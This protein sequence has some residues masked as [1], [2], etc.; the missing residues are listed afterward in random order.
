MSEARRYAILIGNSEFPN[1]P[2]LPA[3]RCPQHDVAG[4]G[5]VLASADFG[6]FTDVLPL[7]NEPHYK[8]KPA[9]NRVFRQ[10]ARQDQIL[11]YYSGHGKQDAVGHLH[12]ATVDTEAEALETTSVEVGLLPRLIDNH[13]CKQVAL[14]LDCC[15]SGLVGKDF[16]K[17]GVDDQLQ[18]M[19]E[20]RGIYILTASTATQTAREKEGDRYSVLTKHILQGI[21][22]G[23]ADYDDDGLVS[24]DDLYE[25]VRAAVP[26]DSPQHPMKWVLGIQ[27]KLAI[28]RAAKIYQAEQLREFKAKVVSVEEFLPDEVFDH[29]LQIIRA[30]QAK[31]DK[32]FLLLLEAL[33]HRSMRVGE[34][35]SRWL[36]LTAAP[37]VQPP[38]QS[39]APPVVPRQN[40][41]QPQAPAS[42][43]PAKLQQPVSFT[44][45]LNDV[46]L[47]MVYLPGDTFK[48]GS[49]KGK[50]YDSERPQH[51]VTVPGFFIGK[52]QITQVQW[53]AVMGNNPAHFKGDNLPV[54][55]VSWEDAQEF[56]RRLSQLTGEAYRLPSE[57][58][59]EYACRAGTTG[60]YA[61]E[62]DKLAW[63]DKNSGQKTHPVGEKEPNAFGLYDMHGNVWECC[64]D[65]WHGNYQGAPSDGSAWVKDSK[66]QPRVVRGGSWRFINGYCRSASRY[67]Y[68][69]GDRDYYFGLRVV[70]SARTS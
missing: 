26:Q 2:S 65:V 54:E 22:Q 59:W 69:P 6:L 3:L 5:E 23:A 27:G 35:S 32:E 63:Y 4:L 36:K 40:K 66:Q 20:G 67:S 58:E 13:N 45:K 62:L 10:A 7:I 48:M 19:S 14:I 53:Q 43:T 50:G 51:D 60:D 25:Y 68:A 39:T 70:V 57:A 15:Y 49:P 64:E 31:R 11:I 55:Q 16:L 18:V 34:F 52:Y 46:P 28:A 56:C 33:C 17:G 37:A 41:P 21:Q 8:V 1:E 61:G 9:I 44:D 24:M 30:N 12:L 47:E 38:A 42:A 29:A